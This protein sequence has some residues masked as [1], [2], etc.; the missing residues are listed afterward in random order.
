MTLLFYDKTIEGFFTAVFEIFEY[1]YED[2]KIVG[3]DE[4]QNALFSENVTSITNLEKSDRV[5][6]RLE[7]QLG[8][9]GV[10][11]LLYAFLSETEDVEN[12]LLRVIQYSIANPNQNVLKNFSNPDVLQ[13]SKLVKSVGREKHRMEAFVRFELLKDGIYFAKIYP[14]FNVLTLILRHFKNRYQDQK[15]LIYDFKRGYG[16]FYDLE[17]TEIVTFDDEVQL[18]LK[19]NDSLLDEKEI[20]YQKLWAEYFDHTNIKERKNMKLHVQHVPKRYWKYLT[21]KKIF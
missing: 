4:N 14:D 8:K 18:Q 20:V 10:R 12:V 1:K 3:A 7:K 16:V 5:L 15:W 11:Q 17:V 13:V 9:E 21:E 6:N 19:N 2:V